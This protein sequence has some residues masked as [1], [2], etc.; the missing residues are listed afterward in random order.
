MKT[1]SIQQKVYGAIAILSLI[2]V[3]A[4]AIIDYYSTKIVEDSSVMDALGRQ[5][6][7][8]QAMGKAAFGYAMAKGRLKTL[9]NKILSLDSYITIM[10]GTYTKYV[11]KT[12]KNIK[13]AISM[14]PESEE[15][16][17]VPFPATFARVVNEKFKKGNSLEVDIIAENPVNP[18]KGLKTDMDREAN[19]FLKK[20]PEKIFTKAFEEN[21]KLLVG[22]YTADI[23]TVAACAN[24]HTQRMG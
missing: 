22:L 1:L 7:L 10:R 24:C 4:G 2:V 12:A 18:N 13:L 23:A 3:I 16:P 8:T 6:M 15:H 21:G 9:E 5:R 20:Y 14:N 11:I 17:A 19:E